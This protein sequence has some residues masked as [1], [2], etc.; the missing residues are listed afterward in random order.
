L[1]SVVGVCSSVRLLISLVVV[2][3]VCDAGSMFDD[4]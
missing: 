1:K 3:F 4:Q 2:G